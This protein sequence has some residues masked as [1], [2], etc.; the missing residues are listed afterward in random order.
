MS[1]SNAVGTIY[2]RHG[3]RSFEFGLS[4]W[5]FPIERWLDQV[6]FLLY[7]GAPADHAHWI[8][9]YLKANLNGMESGDCRAL[10][11][12][13][14]Q[15]SS[16]STYVIIR[17]LSATAILTCFYFAREKLG[18]GPPFSQPSDLPLS[19]YGSKRRAG[20][21]KSRHL[22]ANDTRSYFKRIFYTGNSYQIKSMN[23][24]RQWAKNRYKSIINNRIHQICPIW[25]WF[26]RESESLLLH[27]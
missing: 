14:S 27:K 12:F 5:R 20:I 3:Q 24:W 16:N 22:H 17:R 2:L 4:A 18:Q 19:R 15:I 11:N 9:K 1:K 21:R 26:Q 10:C 6:V 8:L 23:A 7:L 13:Y 25:W